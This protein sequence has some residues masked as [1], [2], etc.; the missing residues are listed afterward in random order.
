[1]YSEQHSNPLIF[2]HLTG[3]QFLFSIS[4]GSV[5]HKLQ[6][7]GQTNVSHLYNFIHE[8][9]KMSYHLFVSCSEELT[10]FDLNSE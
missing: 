6:V 5:K 1:M 9:D 3:N 10:V 7:Y 2:K 4:P 8:G